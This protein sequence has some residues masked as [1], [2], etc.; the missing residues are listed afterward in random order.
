G[1]RLGAAIEDTH[2]EVGQRQVR[3]LMLELAEVLA[4]RDVERVDRPVALGDRH[5]L[6][7]VDD[8]LHDRLGDGL[9]IA[10]GVVAALDH[11]V[12]G[13]DLEE[14]GHRAQRPLGESLEARIRAYM[15]VYMRLAYLD[16]RD[17]RVVAWFVLGARD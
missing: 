4:Q 12:E 14:I 5:L 9:D 6:F 11:A 8:E 3:D 13:R 16:E 10:V 15:G 7:P 2:L 17:Q 1:Y